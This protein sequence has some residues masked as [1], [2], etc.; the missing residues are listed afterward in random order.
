MQVLLSFA[1]RDL[2]YSEGVCG[3]AL[4]PSQAIG[5]YF[6]GQDGSVV[7]GSGVSLYFLPLYRLLQYLQSHWKV[8]HC[9]CI[10]LSLYI[11][12]SSDLSS[13]SSQWRSWRRCS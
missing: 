1:R 5:G 4:N 3:L 2:D 6:I 9:I 11:C 10:A 13:F 7:V 8:S 12:L